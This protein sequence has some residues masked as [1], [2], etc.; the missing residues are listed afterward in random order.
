[1]ENIAKELNKNFKE[2]R[3]LN[4]SFYIVRFNNKTYI[5]KSYKALKK[6]TVQFE[7]ELAQPCADK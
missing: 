3:V 1:M 7:K 2:I 6:L 4:C 5:R